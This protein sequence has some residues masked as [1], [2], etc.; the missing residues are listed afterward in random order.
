MKQCRSRFA[1][2]NEA[3]VGRRAAVRLTIMVVCMLLAVGGLLYAGGRPERDTRVPETSTATVVL[4]DCCSTVDTASSAGDMGHESLAADAPLSGHSV[5]HLDATWTDHRS[6]RFPL[7][8]FRG[9]PVI[10]TML[11]TRCFGTCPVLMQ[12]ARRVYDSLPD[13]VQQ[14]TALVA[15]TFDHEYDTPDVLFEYAVYRHYNRPNWHFLHG[16]RSQVRELATALGV[17]Y[18]FRDNGTIAHTDRIVA[19]DGDGLVVATLDGILQPVGPMTEALKA[20]VK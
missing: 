11:Y 14:Q 15:V 12:D 9:R 19:L 2:M 20:A 18:S 13:E 4:E 7:E 1:R 8:R 16:G 17:R 10:L 5:Y 6:D 3:I